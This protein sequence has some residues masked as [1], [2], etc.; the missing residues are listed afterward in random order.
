MEINVQAASD[1]VNHRVVAG[2]TSNY[3]GKLNTIKLFLAG[4]ENINE[5]IDA[6]NDIVVPLDFDLIQELFGWLSRNTDIPGRRRRRRLVDVNH[7]DDDND[8]DR[9]EVENEGEDVFARRNVTISASTMQGYKSALKWYYDEKGIEF[10]SD[11]DKWL[12]N[13][14]QGYKKIVSEKRRRGIMPITEGKS[15]ISFSGYRCIAE[16]F[17]L[18]R[19]IARKHTWLEGIFGWA[20][21]VLDIIY[22]DTYS[23][24]LPFHT[25]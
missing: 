7:D 18:M 22:M 20:F 17:M 2:T 4:K 25:R 1:V 14:I 12:D 15:P 6:E 8:E 5:L 9:E 23:F 19:P 11:I 21:M 10:A 24:Y 16:T 13:F 3:R